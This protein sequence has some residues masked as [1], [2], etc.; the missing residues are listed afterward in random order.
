MGLMTFGDIDQYLNPENYDGA[1]TFTTSMDA[2][3]QAMVEGGEP[4]GNLEG[5]DSI[6]CTPKTIWAETITAINCP[7]GSEGCAELPTAIKEALGE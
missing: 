3:C 5:T 1:P 7:D 4:I 2:H 6:T